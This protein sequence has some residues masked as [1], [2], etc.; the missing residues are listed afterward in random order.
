[1]KT[2]AEKQEE[3]F[4]KIHNKIPAHNSAFKPAKVL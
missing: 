3:I 1:V 4:L 2:R